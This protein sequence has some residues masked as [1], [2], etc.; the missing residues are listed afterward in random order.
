MLSQS[1]SYFLS[2]IPKFPLSSTPHFSLNSS[3]GGS[4]SGGRVGGTATAVSFQS[5]GVE[6]P[7]SLKLQTKK[8]ASAMTSNSKLSDHTDTLHSLVTDGELDR[9]ADVANKVADASGEVIRTYFRKK[10]DIL[11]K[12]DSSPVTIADKAAEESMV[13]IILENFPS[14]A[15]Y[16]EENGWRCKENFSDYV[17]VLDPIDGTKSFITGKPLFGTLIAL[18]HR[19][20]PILGIIDQPVLKERWI[21]ITGRRTTLNGE[22]LSTRSCAKLS[23]AYLYTTSPHLFNGEADEAFTRVRS[24]VKV[25]LYGCDCYAYALLAS[26]YVDLVIES[27][28]KP[29]DFLSLVPVIEGAGGIIT[30][31]KGHHLCWDASPNS[32]ATSFNVL[33]AGD[34]QIHQQALDSLEWH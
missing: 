29:Y 2:Q 8:L 20:K 24:K 27:G 19:G 18:L 14:H 17:W 10:F 7:I 9:F 3:T 23:Q 6:S 15:I 26:G 21:G 12:E 13:K 25:P 31:W 11:D 4:G 32:R 22:E 34:E 16:G 5:S 1:Q 33:A 28:L 30:D